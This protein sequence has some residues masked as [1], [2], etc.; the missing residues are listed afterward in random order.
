M[1]FGMMVIVVATLLYWREAWQKRPPTKLFS[2]YRAVPSVIVSLVQFLRQAKPQRSFHELWLVTGII[3]G[4][5]LAL[6]VVETIWNFVIVSPARLHT[7]RCSVIANQAVVNNR[8]QKELTTPAVSAQEQRQ[9]KRASDLLKDFSKEER[10]VF[11]YLLDHGE[12]GCRNLESSGLDRIAF[13]EATRKGFNC[14]LLDRREIEPHGELAR[15]MSRLRWEQRF[16]I[17]PQLESALKFVLENGGET[18]P[19]L[20][21]GTSEEDHESRGGR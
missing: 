18:A 13:A 9:R 2:L 17:N 6:F 19:H 21:T 11:Q 7:E 3:L 16:S 15:W 5:Y 1:P 8:L 4:V 12:T 10:L 20:G 14:S